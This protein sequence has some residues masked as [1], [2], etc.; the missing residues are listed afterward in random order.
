MTDVLAAED[1]V[2]GIPIG[3]SVNVRADYP[4]A[5]LAEAPN[6][7]LASLFVDFVLSDEGRS[8]LKAHGFGEP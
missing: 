2:S 7:D 4:I 8:I 1:E 3:D 6:P 5:V